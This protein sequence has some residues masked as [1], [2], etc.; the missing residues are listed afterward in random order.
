MQSFAGPLSAIS[1]LPEL[2]DDLV[3]AR[4]EPLRHF[5]AK[6]LSRLKVYGEFVLGWRLLFLGA[7]LTDRLRD[8]RVSW[9]RDVHNDLVQPQAP[10]RISRPP[11][12]ELD[13]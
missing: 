7:L 11:V 5:E 3:G 4:K 6:R 8:F 12:K 9:S 13:P 10:R 2:F 1:R